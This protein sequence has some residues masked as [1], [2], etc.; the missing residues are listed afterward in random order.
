M[1]SLFIIICHVDH[2]TFPG[3]VVF[4]RRFSHHHSFNSWT[5]ISYISRAQ[6][7]SMKH[8]T[9]NSLMR[10]H[11]VQSSSTLSTADSVFIQRIKSRIKTWIN[12]C[13]DSKGAHEG[14]DKMYSMRKLLVVFYS[15][16]LHNW[17]GLSLFFQ[18][19]W[20]KLWEKL[21]KVIMDPDLVLM[22]MFVVSVKC[23]LSLRLH[24]LRSLYMLLHD[25]L[26]ACCP[27]FHNIELYS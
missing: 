8:L 9:G 24:I 26:D 12:V 7:S 16:Y 15:L 25:F 18:I 1:F 3:F 13:K 21:S 20:W 17:N 6:E 27:M 10:A 11:A 14:W 19:Q 4:F 2:P 23:N 22:W 5:G